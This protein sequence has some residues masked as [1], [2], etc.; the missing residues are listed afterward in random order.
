MDILH[1]FGES[2]GLKTNLQKSNVLPIRCGEPEL[3]ILQQLLPCEISVFPC[4][5]LGLPLSLKKLT[6]AQIQP[7][8]DQIADQLPGWKADLMT[9]AG[10]KVQV[11]F[12][13]TAMLIYLA[14]ALDFPPWAIKAVDKLRRGFL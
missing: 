9:R 11:Q 13:L 12:V 5:Y 3:D 10:R 4:R 1:L 8:I 7:I 2:S 14:M 6:K